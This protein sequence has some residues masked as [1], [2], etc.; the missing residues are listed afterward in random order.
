MSIGGARL[1]TVTGRPD[2]PEKAAITSAT[3]NHSV[4]TGVAYMYLNV[5]IPPLQRETG[6]SWFLKQQRKCPVASSAA[7]APIIIFHVQ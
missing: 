5:Y 4:A 3:T 1:F 2:R 7:M 6:A